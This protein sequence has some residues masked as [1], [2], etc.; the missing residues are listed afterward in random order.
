M[1]GILC[2]MMLPFRIP[3]PTVYYVHATIQTNFDSLVYGVGSWALKDNFNYF[4][5]I[6]KTARVARLVPSTRVVAI[7]T[8]INMYW[9][10]ERLTPTFYWRGW[11][12]NREQARRMNEEID[13]K[14]SSSNLA[15][16][17]SW[18]GLDIAAL[19]AVKVMGGEERREKER[20]NPVHR[21]WA[22]GKD[23]LRLIGVLPNT[24][25][26]MD[27]HIAATKIQRAWRS[28]LAKTKEARSDDGMQGGSVEGNFVWTGREGASASTVKKR[29]MLNRTIN[30]AKIAGRSSDK[31]IRG[32]E[33]APEY[34]LSSN[35]NSRHQ[36]H[37]N[38]LN[39]K[40][41]RADRSQVGPAMAE[42]TGERVGV[43][44]LLSLLFVLMFNYQENDSTRPSTMV[45]LH[46]QTTR[47]QLPTSARKAVDTARKNAIPR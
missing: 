40:H 34:Q 38:T 16:R 15:R 41:S 35:G 20:H 42:N 19:A 7:S 13:L 8:R 2:T 43:F 33:A 9:Y 17:A 25:V 14:R 44:I 22:I 37:R 27:R 29:S 47:S 31:H 46:G 6:F 11:K 12:E 32:A 3:D 28:R 18:G 1:S 10:V 39:G 24:N 30:G 45:V 21:A 23:M 5:M 36:Y 4:V 26:E